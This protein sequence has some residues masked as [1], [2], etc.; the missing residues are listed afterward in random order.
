MS[1][2]IGIVIT[3]IVG[4]YAASAYTYFKDKKAKEAK[5]KR[6]MDKYNK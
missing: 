5:R 1:V 4:V 6:Q 3:F 2:M